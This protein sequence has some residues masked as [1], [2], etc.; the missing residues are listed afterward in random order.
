MAQELS[1]KYPTY[2]AGIQLNLPLR[3]RVAQADMTRDQLALRAAQTARLNVENHAAVEIQTAMLAVQ[4]SR[5]AY[6]AAVRTRQLQEESLDVEMA[7]F[8]AGVDT[9]LFVIQYQAYL[10]QARSTEVVAKGDYFK[11][12]AG[13]DRAAGRILDIHHIAVEE[14][15]RGRLSAQPSPPRVP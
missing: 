12:V 5:A 6:Q 7:R 9:I 4:R 15:Y 8:Q 11:A 14:A 3:N 10:A 1:G 2:E 13:L